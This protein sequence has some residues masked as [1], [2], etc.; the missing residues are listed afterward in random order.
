MVIWTPLFLLEMQI[1][2]SGTQTWIQIQTTLFILMAVITVK[3]L[4]LQLMVLQLIPIM[5]TMTMIVNSHSYIVEKPT[6]MDNFFD[7]F[8]Y[9][10]PETKEFSY[11]YNSKLDAQPPAGLIALQVVDYHCQE[12]TLLETQ[13]KKQ[14]LHQQDIDCHHFLL[15]I[16]QTYH[17]L[18]SL[19]KPDIFNINNNQKHIFNQLIHFALKNWESQHIWYQERCCSA[20]KKNFP[21]GFFGLGRNLNLLPIALTMSRTF[22]IKQL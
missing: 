17:N 3:I 13:Q 21:L 10:D 11:W 20:I 8:N 15:S 16:S 7:I 12:I 19:D 18:T 14:K 6:K 22:V 9:T 1:T 5:M 4:S 2:L